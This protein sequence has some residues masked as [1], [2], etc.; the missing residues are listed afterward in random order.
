MFPSIPK[1]ISNA[2]FNGNIIIIGAGVS[3]LMAAN[4]LKYMGFDNYEVLEGSDRV[5]GRLKAAENFHEEVPLDLGAEWIHFSDERVVKDMLVFKEDIEKGLSASEFIRYKPQM[6]FGSKRSRFMEF[7][8]QETKWKRSTWFHW[9]E[10]HV[11]GHVKEKVLL[12]STVQLIDYGNEG[13]PIKLVLADGSE[14]FADKVICTIPLAV[15]KSDTIKFSPEL[16][17]KK[18]S[19]IDAMKMPPGFRILF[20]MKEKFYP[21]VTSANSFWNTIVN[22]GYEVCAMYDALYKKDLSNSQNVLAYVAIGEVNAGEMSKLS[23][24]E[25]A[26]AA[27]AKI[28]EVFNGQASKNYVKHVVQNWTSDPYIM[29][30]YSTPGVSKSTRSEVG[31]TIDEKLLFAGEHTSLKYFSLVHGAAIEGQNAAIEAVMGNAKE[32]I[33]C[34]L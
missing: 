27:L 9:L 31:K 23:D 30:S 21:D 25:L 18:R 5:G 10:L 24:D 17:E 26:K 29:G 12:N 1:D 11:Y 14:K 28:D 8:Y 16:P 33:S 34:S 20:Q 7:L 2:K 3:G 13:S 6:W 22:D 19:A 4:T 32:T 15:L